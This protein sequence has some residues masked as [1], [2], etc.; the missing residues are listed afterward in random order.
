M[1][2]SLIQKVLDTSE[3]GGANTAGQGGLTYEQANTFLDYMWDSTVLGSLVTKKRMNAVE[4]EWDVVSVGAKLVRLATEGVDDGVNRVPSFTKLSITTKKLR[5]DWEL[6]SESLEDNIEGAD[7]EDHIVRLM[8]TQFG[9][10]VEDLAVNGDTA[11]TGDA[12]YKSF[13]GW[14]KRAIAGASIVD[15][16]GGTLNRTV[17]HKALK[18]MPRKYMA[19]RPSLK[20]LT[21]SGAIQDYI[22][23]MQQDEN[24]FVNPES[25]AAA[26]INQAVRTEGPAGFMT[27]NS[28]GVPV[29]EIP[30]FKEDLDGTYSG[31]TGDHTEVWLTVP[32][33]L[34]WGV[35][36][37]V[38]VHKEFKP[39]KD[40]IEY[41]VYT[42][43]GVQIENVE[44]F[45]VVR[46]VKIA[47]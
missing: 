10:D 34:I 12:L 16:A 47:A 20:F 24:G 17:F 7:L 39:K 40:T 41:T 46:N 13:D 18:A 35:K 1:T 2:D 4:V 26:G 33:N 3:I 31:A 44:A 42:R 5:L 6:T 32:K 21:G 8:A 19:A 43:Q 9:N 30:A 36:R 29:Q 38:E 37:E 27:G 14:R 11:L 25:K 22:F 28:F 15:H 45:V 23:S